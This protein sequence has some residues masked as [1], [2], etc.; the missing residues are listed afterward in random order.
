MGLKK[1]LFS[2]FVGLGCVLDR[3]CAF[4]WLLGAFL[5]DGGGGY[6]HPYLFWFVVLAVLPIP[7]LRKNLDT[8]SSVRLLLSDFYII[9]TNSVSKNFL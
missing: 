7:R 4:P 6:T 3:V 2:A 9:L 8:K 5:G 1:G